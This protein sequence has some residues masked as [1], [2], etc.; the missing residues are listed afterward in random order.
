MKNIV[1]YKG[2]NN[3]LR[4]W[5]YQPEPKARFILILDNAPLHLAGPVQTQTVA[6]LLEVIQRIPGCGEMSL[7]EVENWIDKDQY[8][9]PYKVFNDSQLIEIA[10]GGQK[11]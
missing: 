9:P 4:V 2:E 7:K 3:F 10:K 5:R 1:H 8:E 11:K 6:G